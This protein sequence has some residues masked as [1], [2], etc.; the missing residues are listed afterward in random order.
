MLHYLKQATTK[1]Y[2][3][4]YMIIAHMSST[5]NDSGANKTSIM[6]ESYLSY[7]QL[8]EYLSLLL[9]KGLV[10]E[11]SKQIGPLSVGVI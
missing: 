3:V 4:R 2:R 6:Y 9:E 5:I 10:V 8:K 1:A 7:A 11:L